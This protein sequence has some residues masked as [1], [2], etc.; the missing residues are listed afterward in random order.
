[1][2]SLLFRLAIF[3]LP[4]SHLRVWLLQSS[5][6]H[7]PTPDRTL[8][9][10]YSFPS[11]GPIES[12][13]Q[14]DIYAQLLWQISWKTSLYSAIKSFNSKIP[15]P[16]L[17]SYEFVFHTR[18]YFVTSKNNLP[19]KIAYLTDLLRIW[20]M[21]YKNALSDVTLCERVGIMFLND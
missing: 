16:K 12:W 21:I 19:D 3:R 6:L 9:V 5:A 11:S 20:D 14:T 15:V 1:M 7:Q 17:S 4:L 13:T 10:S 18:S 2:T 8:W